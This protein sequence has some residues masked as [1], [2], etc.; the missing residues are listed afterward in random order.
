MRGEARI[1]WIER[2]LDGTALAAGFALLLAAPAARVL[3]TWPMLVVLGGVVL[4]ASGLTRDLP[5]S[6]SRAAR[7]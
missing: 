5:G 1:V 4:L 3:I 2:G 7:W 6:R